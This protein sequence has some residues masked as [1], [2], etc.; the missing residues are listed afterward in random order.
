[1]FGILKKLFKTGELI[2]SHFRLENNA[3]LVYF[4]LRK[5]NFVVP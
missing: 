3:E 2:Y 4:K 1:M 5:G